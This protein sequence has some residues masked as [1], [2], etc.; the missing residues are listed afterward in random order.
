MEVRANV[1]GDDG[2]IYY[3]VYLTLIVAF[4][5]FCYFRLRI[6][7]YQ[8]VFITLYGLYLVFLRYFKAILGW[9]YTKP[10]PEFSVPKWVRPATISEYSTSFNLKPCEV[11]LGYEGK[12]PIKIDIT[13]HHTL[14]GATS[15]GAKTN[16]I[17]SILLQL[18]SHPGFNGW[19]YLLDMKSHPADRFDLWK[20]LVKRYEKRDYDGGVAA[21]LK[22]LQEIEGLLR[23]EV[24]QPLIVIIDEVYPLTQ[25]KEGDRLLGIIASQIRLNG[26]LILTVQHP[27]HQVLKTFTKHNI[28]RRM[29]GV[30]VNDK[31]AEIILESKP[32]VPLPVLPGQFLLREPGRRGLVQL[33]ADEVDFD[34][35][36]QTIGTILERRIQDDWRISLYRDV[37]ENKKIG[38]KVIGVRQIKEQYGRD[39]QEKVMVAFRNFAN[40]GLFH[41]PE[42]RGKS[43]TVRVPW[44]EGLGQLNNYFENWE[45]NPDSL[46]LEE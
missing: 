6:K 23:E 16:E 39:A 33:V 5:L 21:A 14:I 26:S 22:V 11:V 4:V 40:A 25:N 24:S 30:V 41:A 9:W 29:C 43:Y 15:G 37:T 27:H 13:D 1:A 2:L 18:Y 42:R 35:I 38:E 10:Y 28:E 32:N 36:E 7:V 3:Y 46:I 31:Q 20:P 17:H 19:V 44:P 8:I 45:E 34:E 12:R